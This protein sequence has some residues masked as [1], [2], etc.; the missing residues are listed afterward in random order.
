MNLAAPAPPVQKAEATPAPREGSI[1][2][3]LAPESEPVRVSAAPRVGAA[4]TVDDPRAHAPP[5]LL[6]ATTQT[7]QQAQESL[8]VETLRVMSPNGRLDFDSYA[9]VI[10]GG[11]QK[12]IARKMLPFLFDERDFLAYGEVKYFVAVSG[13]LCLVY[14]EETSQK[15][16]YAIDLTQFTAI[17]EDP[18]H[19]D[20][21]SFTISPEPD[22]NKPRPSMITILL[23]EKR[24]RKQAYQF[25]FET[26]KD[27]TMAKRF[28]DVVM[29][30][31]ASATNKKEV[32]EGH[33]VGKEK[34]KS[35]Y[36]T[37]K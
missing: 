21:N 23:K 31:S 11:P 30:A 10:R 6:H 27:K 32:V 9:A 19:P 28:L 12:N 26:A 4:T 22:T 16:Y 25:T 24:S 2:V 5:N 15:P 33:L 13:E 35:N 8:G 17:Q 18:N 34:G 37:Q 14:A 36:H 20:P 7:M 1:K 3:D 29:V